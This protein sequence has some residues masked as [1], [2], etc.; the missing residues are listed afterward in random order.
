ME[1]WFTLNDEHPSAALGTQRLALYVAA[2]LMDVDLL[3]VIAER[4][5]ATSL[6]GPTNFQNPRADH[7]PWKFLVG[8]NVI[9]LSIRT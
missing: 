4:N 2:H 5:H 1:F 8:G 9:K 7:V 6:R 3:R